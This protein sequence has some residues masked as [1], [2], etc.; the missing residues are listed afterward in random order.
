MYKKITA[1]LLSCM[2]TIAGATCVMA[3][4][5]IVNVTDE[6]PVT[7]EVSTEYIQVEDNST[8]TVNSTEKTNTSNTDFNGYFFNNKRPADITNSAGFLLLKS[9]YRFISI[10]SLSQYYHK[11]A[12]IP[13]SHIFI[14]NYSGLTSDMINETINCIYSC[15]EN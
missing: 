9:L 3:D 13:E 2:L 5:N 14:I 1:V 4:D 6:Y 12:D 15:I 10:S 7:T 8:D 11:E